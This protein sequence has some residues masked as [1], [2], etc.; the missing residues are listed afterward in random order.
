MWISLHI[1]VQIKC[2]SP[3]VN[4]GLP[5]RVAKQYKMEKECGLESLDVFHHPVLNACHEFLASHAGCQAPDELGDGW[6]SEHCAAA[7]SAKG[8]VPLL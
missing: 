6:V 3:S 1:R 4:W 7:P 5:P 2:L 8:N